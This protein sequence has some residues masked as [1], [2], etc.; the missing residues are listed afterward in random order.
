MH[1]LWMVLC[2]AG[3]LSLACGADLG[4]SAAYATA[5]SDA[6][7]TGVITPAAVLSPQA[8]YY[9]APPP[10]GND[11]N[12]GGIDSP[13]ATLQHAVDSVHPGDTILVQ[14][15][16]YA[17]TRIE[18]SGTQD[19]WITLRA[20][21]DAAVLVNAPG[22]NNVHGSIIEIETWEGDGTVSYW[23]IAG[24]EVAGAPSWGI[25]SRGNEDAHNHHIH[26]T[27]NVVHDNGLESGRTGIFAAF[28][29]DVLIE[30]NESYHNGEHGIYVNNSSDRFTV[31]GN[32]LHDNA[33][34]GLH[35]NGD[36]GMG[37]DGILSGGLVENNIIYNNGAGIDGSGGGGAAINMDG[38]TDSLLRNNLLY[39]NHA[40]GIAVFNID[41]AVCSQNNRLLHNTILM[42]ADGRWG[43]LIAGAACA[44]NEITNNIIYSDHNWR[45]SINLAEGAPQGFRSD[46]NVVVGRFTTDDGTVIDLA[47]WQALGYDTHSLVAAPGDLFIDP[48]GY[49][50]HLLAGSP[51]V[52]QGTAAG[53]TADLDGNRRPVGNGYDIGAYEYQSGEP[54]LLTEAIFLPLVM[55]TLERI[56][57][58]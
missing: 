49:D 45:G 31:R 23:I 48:I 55:Q 44:N 26:I 4:S 7:E 53:V 43:I 24:F 20:A 9:V 41:G 18:R 15:G 21:P 38:V 25:D 37:G 46:Y 42:P 16:T 2:L 5:T 8:V 11:A 30:G 33:N 50:F 17:G 35:L 12:L 47:S 40:T 19:A 1:K 52:D 22:P 3:L 10:Q 51:A 27:G 6:P 57:Q 29:S 28:T 14:S 58:Y 54:P 39:N 36:W 34:C 13:W 32:R 56:T